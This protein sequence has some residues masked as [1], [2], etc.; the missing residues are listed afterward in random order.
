MSEDSIFFIPVAEDGS[1]LNYDSRY[2]LY[3]PLHGAV[4]LV[5]Q[6][7]KTRI[8]AKISDLNGGI[9]SID[10]LKPLLSFPKRQIQAPPQKLED[11]YEIDILTNYKCNFSC[12]YCYSARGRSDV[13]LEFDIACKLIDFL[14]SCK[15]PALKPYKINF[16]GGGEPLISFDLISRII[17]YIEQKADISGH[18]YTL[19]LVTNG[20]L[21]S[22][23][24][25]EFFKNHGVRLVV[26][27]SILER[28]QNQERG[29]YDSVAQAIDLLIENGNR[30]GVRA[31][32]TD[33]S[34]SAM[35]EMV[36]EINRRFPKLKA[37]VFDTVLSKDMF[38]TDCKLRDY[39]NCFEKN[40]LS[41]RS[42]GAR[43]GIGVYSTAFMATEFV[44]TRACFGKIVLTPL[45][46]LSICARVSSP[47]E[48]EYKD[49][50]YGRIDKSAGL[51]VNKEI[52]ARYMADD[53]IYAT[54]DCKSCY[55]RWHCGGGCRLCRH[56]LDA[57]SMREECN[58][59]RHILKN[60]L[61][62]KIG[63]V[64]KKMT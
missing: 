51:Q 6:D 18:K 4:A 57:A 10:E 11:V 29:D 13:E 60:E 37:V 14:F 46:A 15:H 27:F 39:Y 1:K 7:D 56:S 32:L 52:F 35:P 2:I 20:S 48:E 30:F 25:A 44:R 34:V 41:A 53:T 63:A 59:K 38:K 47:R 22:K 61:M 49:F 23:K 26:S 17:E 54:R 64:E 62:R 8:E 58:F 19:Q 24:H 43:L 21:L 31:T 28:F 16:S 36:Q 5:S 42:L 45:G 9:E 40:F 3:A 12:V 50:I 55:A 33:K